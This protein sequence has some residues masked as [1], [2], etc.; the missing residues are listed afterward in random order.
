MWK[1]ERKDNAM[2]QL[3]INVCLHQM[4]TVYMFD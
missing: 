3:G 1:L 2:G 4:S